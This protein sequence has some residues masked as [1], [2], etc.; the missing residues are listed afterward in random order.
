MKKLRIRICN[1]VDLTR[2]CSASI[3]GS[4]RGFNDFVNAVETFSNTEFPTLKAMASFTCVIM[5]Q[6]KQNPY[7]MDLALSERHVQRWFHQG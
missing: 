5:P 3:R 6:K 4:S 2:P 1:G 7:D